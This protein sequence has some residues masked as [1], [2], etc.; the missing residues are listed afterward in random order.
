MGTI[1]RAGCGMG[2][3][4]KRVAFGGALGCKWDVS[5]MRGNSGQGWLVFHGINTAWLLGKESSEA[6]EKRFPFSL[7]L[8][9]DYASHYSGFLLL[10]SPFFGRKEYLWNGMEWNG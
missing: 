1:D 6:E 4:G 2:L 7:F 9:D 3:G 10:C 5:T 8:D